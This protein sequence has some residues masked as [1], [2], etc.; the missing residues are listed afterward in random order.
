MPPQNKESVST[1]EEARQRL[2]ASEALPPTE[3]TPLAAATRQAPH[4][5]HLSSLATMPHLGRQHVR[6]ASYFLGGAITFFIIAAAIAGYFL[7]Y[8]GNSV[9]VKN[10]ELTLQGPSTIAG[11]DTVPFS[12][13]VTNRNP[14]AIQDATIE[15]DF[16][17]GTRSAEDVLTPL[18]TYS[19]NLGTLKSG[20]TVTRSIKAVVFGAAGQTLTLPVS[21][22]YDAQ[23]SNATF[24]KK[25]SYPLAISSTPLSISVDTIAETVAGKPFTI[26]L[27]VRSN[28]TV[29]IEN[30]V[31][32]GTFPFGFTLN[33]SSVEATGSDFPL[34]TLAPGAS[35]TIT[36]SG[37]LDGQTSE[38]RVFHF[39]IGITKDANAA[40]LAVSYMTQDAT[41]AITAPFIASSLTLNG[42]PLSS[43]T[44]TA[45]Q[46]QNVTL[47]YTNTL[48]T[49]LK[50]ATIAIAISGGAVDY[51]SIH[52]AN[53]YYRS[54]DHTVL[55][56][57]DTDSALRSLAPGASGI[58]SFSFSTVPAAAFGRSPSVTFTSSI[59]GTRI[60][61]SNVPE[62]VSASVVQT[63]KAATAVVLTTSSLHTSGPFTN[64]GPVPPVANT[65][66]SYA[67][68]WQVSNGASAIADATVAATLPSYVTYTGATSGQG[69]FNYDP[70]SRTVTWSVGD[71]PQTASLKGAFQVT[72]LPSSSQKGTSPPLTSGASFSGHDR[73][74]GVTITASADPVTTETVNDPGYVATKASVQ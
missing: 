66:T 33:S 21:L 4:G 53:G 1:L 52:T 71:V 58:G 26:M 23:G 62:Q 25:T 13:A 22:S 3:R 74:A 61:Q 35:R 18:T 46:Q 44:L 45:S 11:G 7:Y 72:L 28:A 50:D 20:E 69:S 16:P 57:K 8:G 40:D 59:S 27:R 17:E 6:L 55:F 14:V 29:P 32:A 41:I 64:N 60:G 48:S 47:S 36:L 54:S 43:A 31:V 34:G 39:A 9:S 68:S 42:S 37:V 73:F 70:R 5:W 49:N 30:V 10:I 24:V 19:E 38:D 51:A 15:I 63:V 12:I 2:Y 65:T 56:S 67:I